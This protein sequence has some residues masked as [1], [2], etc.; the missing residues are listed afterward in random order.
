MA[1][2]QHIPILFVDDDTI[3]HKLINKFLEDW[4]VHHAYSAEEALEITETEKNLIIITDIY[5]DGMN[6]IELTRKI[7]KSNQTAQIIVV[8]GGT[9]TINLLNAL[10]AGASDFLL[11]PIKKSKLIEVLESTEV[12]VKRWKETLKHIFSL[13]YDTK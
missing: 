5:M 13:H 12:K 9:E 11:K 10:D 7:K 2:K 6:G 8:T 4:P 3:A 1:T